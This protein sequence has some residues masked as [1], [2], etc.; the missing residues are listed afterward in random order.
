M[1]IPVPQIP[2]LRASPSGSHFPSAFT[3]MTQLATLGQRTGPGKGSP[4]SS[5]SSDVVLVLDIHTGVSE[6][7]VYPFL[8]NG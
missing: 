3:S 1:A 5:F 2:T 4:A 7:V 6:N 8:P